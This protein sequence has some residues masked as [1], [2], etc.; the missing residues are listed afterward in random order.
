LLSLQ[1]RDGLE[2]L[3]NVGFPVRRLGDDWDQTAGPFVDTA[4]VMKN[5]DLVITADTAAAHLAGA[6]GVPVWV[7]LGSRTDWRWG[8]EG[9]QTP[10]Y[11]SMRLFRQSRPGDWGEVFARISAALKERTDQV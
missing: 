4:A 9:E 3:E 2:Q 11:P 8:I 5:L 1:K 10:W 7:A 6:L